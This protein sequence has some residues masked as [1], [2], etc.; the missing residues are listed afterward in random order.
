[1]LNVE[2]DRAQPKWN[3]AVGRKRS[4]A[5]FKR[6]GGSVKMFTI[7]VVKARA[8]RSSISLM[9][10]SRREMSNVKSVTLRIILCVNSSAIAANVQTAKI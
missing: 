2:E 1:M 6:R 3:R 10:P 7:E 5:I 8:R 4:K 9:I